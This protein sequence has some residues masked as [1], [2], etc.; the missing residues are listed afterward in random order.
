MPAGRSAHAIAATSAAIYVM[1][2]TGDGGAPVLEVDRFDG[3]TWTREGKI[4]GEGLNAPAAAA[5]GD[6]IY[7]IGGFGTTT[8]RPTDKVQRYD[9][10]QR[11]WRDAAPLPA[12]RGGHA[13]VVMNGRIHVIGGGNSVS[14]IADH[15]VY[16]P[17]TNTWTAKASLPRSMGSPAAAV[18]NGRLYSIGG[19]SGPNDFGDVYIYDPAADTW[20][21]GPAIAPRG[22]AGAVVIGSSLYVFG[23]ESQAAN[24]VLGDVLRLDPG[25]TRWV[26]DSPMPTPRN[27]ARAVL[28]KGVIYTV[29]GS[30][31]AGSSHASAGS[32][33]VESFRPD[34]RGL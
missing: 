25:V 9:A 23:G 17:A 27:F 13:A 3:A 1:G 34:R 4:P 33:V 8:N 2:G 16:D 15:S 21:A 12:P 31:T 14:T 32:R 7:L 29:G 5:I 24:A 6:A 10:G 11:T 18:M 26:A 22:T 28:F 19:R 30:L 20:T